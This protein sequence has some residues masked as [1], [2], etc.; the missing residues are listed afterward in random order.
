MQRV[1]RCSWPAV[2]GPNLTFPNWRWCRHAFCLDSSLET[3][4]ANHHSLRCTWNKWIY[5][6]SLNWVLMSFACTLFLSSAVCLCQSFTHR[7]SSMLFY[8]HLLN[9]A[10]LFLKVWGH[11]QG[12]Q[13][14]YNSSKQSYQIVINKYDHI[15]VPQRTWE[16]IFQQFYC[17]I[18]F[19]IY[20]IKYWCHP[21]YVCFACG[22]FHP[23]NS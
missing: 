10:A 9:S 1:F 12:L 20:I 21:P 19:F 23:A 7:N 6:E 13:V 5:A 14:D 4:Q 15:L 11:Q 22:H 16:I 2:H 17:S 18:F 3:Q 8:I